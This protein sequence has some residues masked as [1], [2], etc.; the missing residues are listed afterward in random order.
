MYTL[1]KK[2]FPDA[3]FN[4]VSIFAFCWL[5]NDCQNLIMSI[6]TYI[7]SFRPGEC[8][9]AFNFHAR[10]PNIN[11]ASFHN[12]SHIVWQVL[13]RKFSQF[14]VIFREV[15][16]MMLNSHFKQPLMKIKRLKILAEENLKLMWWAWP[17][18]LA[19]PPGQWI[20]DLALLFGFN[21][22]SNTYVTC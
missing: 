9:S 3:H 14:K 2:I 17:E 18:G 4:T 5:L 20:G 1:L 7:L 21:C 13:S 16:S 19:G 6:P 10:D 11:L 12:L 8:I 22:S 15:I